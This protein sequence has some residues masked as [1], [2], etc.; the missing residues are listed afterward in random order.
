MKSK[1]IT[2][3]SLLSLSLFVLGTNLQ[4]NPTG[5]TPAVDDPICQEASDKKASR[6][7]FLGD[8][9]TEGSCQTT[10]VIPYAYP[11]AVFESSEQEMDLAIYNLYESHDNV[12]ATVKRDNKNGESTRFTIPSQKIENNGLQ[13]SGSGHISDNGAI[14]ITYILKNPAGGQADKCSIRLSPCN[15]Q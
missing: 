11:V 10:G 1:L 2:L 7:Q 4:A 9:C 8:Y 12:K 14:S 3:Y 13:I 5:T 15:A 6:D